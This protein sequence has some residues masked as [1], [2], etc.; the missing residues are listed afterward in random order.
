MRPLNRRQFFGSAL[1]ATGGGLILPRVLSADVLPRVEKVA[2]PMVTGQE[3]NVQK[4]LWAA[5]VRYK[6]MRMIVGEVT[7]PVTGES[8]RRLAWYLAYRVVV[9]KSSSLPDDTVGT[10]ERPM[11]VPELSLVAE[12]KGG[13]KAY[14]DQV[15]PELIPAINRRESHEYK[16]SVDVT[17]P[18]PPI[19]PEDS[20]KIVS[21]DGVAVWVG[22]DPNTINFSVVM[23]GFSNGYRVVTGDDG[24]DRVERRMLR[25]RFWRPSDRFDQNER[26]FRFKGEPEWFYQ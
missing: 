23:S 2:S 4:D 22:V 18:L 9:R 7:D 1:A 10:L 21:L 11:F 25:Q 13:P 12:L 5:E 17:G 6:P 24:A 20:R 15:I 14:S 3:Q 19:S 16:S 8:K 26:E